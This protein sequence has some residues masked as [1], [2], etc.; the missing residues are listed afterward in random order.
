MYSRASREDG[1]W[2]SAL[3]G[4]PGVVAAPRSHVGRARA[5]VRRAPDYDRADR[6]EGLRGDGQADH[7][8]F[9]PGAVG[10][11]ETDARGAGYGR[12]F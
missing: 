12:I 8:M 7:G 6:V 11:R 9:G 5:S 3:T 4:L 1:L 10:W 2:S